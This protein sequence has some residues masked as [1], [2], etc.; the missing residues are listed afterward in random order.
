MSVNPLERQLSKAGSRTFL[1]SVYGGRV[2]LPLALQ[3]WTWQP[4]LRAHVGGSKKYAHA[5]L[6]NGFRRQ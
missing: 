4:C 1:D 5:P 2:F 3:P 6:F